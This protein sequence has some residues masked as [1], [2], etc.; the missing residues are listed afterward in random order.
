MAPE[1]PASPSARALLAVALILWAAT[2]L[3][4]LAHFEGCSGLSYDDA[5]YATS[6]REILEEGHGYWG[7]CWRPFASWW[8]AGL[9]ALRGVDVT[10][11]GLAFTLLRSLGELWLI[12]AARGFF[13]ASPWAPLGVAAVSACSFLGVNYGR[14]HLSSLL[15]TVP[16]AL[17]AYANFLRRGGWGRWAMCG[18]AA[19][20]VF[21][22]HFNTIGALVLMLALEGTRRWLVDRR[23]KV[24]ATSLLVGGGMTYLTVGALGLLSYGGNWKRYFKL[25]GNHMAE[26]QVRGDL[27]WAGLDPSLLAFASWEGALFFLYAV[28]LAFWVRRILVSSEERGRLLA[29]AGLP[30]LGCA[31][32]AGR[33]AVGMLSFPRIYVFALPFL[34]LLVGAMAGGVVDRWVAS[35]RSR[36]G[37]AL[38]ILVLL[39]GTLV[40]AGHLTMVARTDSANAALGRWL[41]AHPTEKMAIYSGTPHLPPVFFGWKAQPPAETREMADHFWIEGGA[42]QASHVSARLADP[43]RRVYLTRTDLPEV[44]DLVVLHKPSRLTLTRVEEALRKVAPNAVTTN[45]Y[46]GTLF[47]LPLAADE[48]GALLAVPSAPDVESSPLP[49]IRAW[50][51]RGAPR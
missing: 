23:M 20:L 12:L 5:A 37:W 51:L 49:T 18:F 7:D 22:S 14:Q 8:V 2:T 28:A 43:S 34:W 42:T 30:L 48:G 26:N 39:F 47:S 21:L 16:L 17:L 3:L 4:R 32:V 6:G 29:L 35:G 50:D 9:H 25:V 19:G 38:A 1:R 33:A 31:L 11:V 27:H 10:N 46:D 36:G 41:R 15:F 45:F 40:Q 24:V 13:P 44:C